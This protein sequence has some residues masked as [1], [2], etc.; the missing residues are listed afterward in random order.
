MQSQHSQIANSNTSSVE[1]SELT[2]WKPPLVAEEVADFDI[3]SPYARAKANKTQSTVIYSLC[4]C[5]S[6]R[7][8]AAEIS[9]SQAQ[10]H[11][12]QH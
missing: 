4:I 6:F 5:R 3:F 11:P 1:L 10:G 2:V 7:Q 8:T 9:L 12:T